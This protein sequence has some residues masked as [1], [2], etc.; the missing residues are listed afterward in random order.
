MKGS[1]ISSSP[2]GLWSTL[3]DEPNSAIWRATSDGSYSASSAYVFQFSSRIKSPELLQAWK[4]KAEGKI[5]N[6]CGC[7][8][9]TDYGPRTDCATE[10]ELGRHM[11]SFWPSH[12]RCK[13]SFPPLPLLKRGLE[14]FWSGAA[15]ARTYYKSLFEHCSFVGNFEKL[16]F[17]V[18]TKT[19]TLSA[20]LLLQVELELVWRRLGSPLGLKELCFH[21]LFG[22]A[23]LPLCKLCKAFPPLNA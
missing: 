12:R 8:S 18:R 3:T 21:F 7:Y 19:I 14:W 11:Q 13:S 17:S 15:A 9:R 6:F 16:D 23:A 4:S 22:V 5:K 20:L 10:G 1:W 2:F